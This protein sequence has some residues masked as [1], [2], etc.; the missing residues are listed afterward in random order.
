VVEE[1]KIPTT[2]D[3]EDVEAHG[4][5]DRPTDDKDREAASDEP[6][7][8]GHGFTDRPTDRPTD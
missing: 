4:Y 6:D 2:S 1:E 3:T 5:T 7:V 8:E